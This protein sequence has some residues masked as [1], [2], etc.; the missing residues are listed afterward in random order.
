MHSRTR[1]VAVLAAGAAA[2]AWIAVQ[3]QGS[4]T[5][6]GVSEVSA[7]RDVV[8]SLTG[9]YVSVYPAARAFKAATPATRATLVKAA[10]A[11]AKAYTESAAFK[12]EYEKARLADTPA[13]PKTKGT[14]DD[15]LAAQRA[16]RQKSLE[17]MKKNVAKMP[18]NM[19]PQMEQT[20]KQTEAQFAKMDA[21][22]KMAGLMR[23]GLEAQRA[24]DQ[25]AYQDRVR[26][27]EKSFPADPR[28]LIARRLQEFLTTSADVDFN[29]KLVPAGSKQRFADPKLEEKSAEWKLCYRAGKE[30][31]AAAREAAQAWLAALK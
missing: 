13:P 4:L 24:N 1:A 22:A 23:Q 31:V 10:I 19:R 26:A 3:A 9:G 5:G 7:K 8:P 29:A 30:P 21:D 14:V 27:F 2:A 11:W 12:A 16:E 15:E 25:K 18:A 6:L 20:I 28:A 17:E